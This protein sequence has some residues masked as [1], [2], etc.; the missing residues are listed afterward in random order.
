MPKKL[1]RCVR[2]VKASNKGKPKSKQVNPWAICQKSTGQK[3]H[4]R[5]KK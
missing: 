4:K 2:H 1:E 5:G 3:S